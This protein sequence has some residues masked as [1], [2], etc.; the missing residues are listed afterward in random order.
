M[1]IK[2]GNTSILIMM[3]MIILLFN[4]QLMAKIKI[5]YYFVIQQHGHL[6][7]PGHAA[8][9]GAGQPVR[10]AHRQG[11]LQDQRDQGGEPDHCSAWWR[12]LLVGWRW[13]LSS[14]CVC[15]RQEL[16]YRWL[17]TCC[18]TLLR[19]PLLSLGLRCPSSSVSNRSVWSCWR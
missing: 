3:N 6:Q 8:D 9:R 13:L 12:A 5:P 2:K 7:A 11:R 15:S 17:E 1:D 4:S 14:V 16:R 10:L 18:L 19:E